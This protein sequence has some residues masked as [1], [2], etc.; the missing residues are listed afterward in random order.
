VLVFKKT[1]HIV[2]RCWKRFDHNY[3][4]KEKM[5][6]NAE[7]PRYSVNT[8]WYSDTGSTDHVTSELDKLAM[9]EKYT[10]PEQ[11]HAASGGGMHIA[12]VGHSM[13]Y[14]PTRHLMLKNFMHVPNSHKNLVSIHWFTRDNHMFIEY[15]PYF[16][17]V[18][19]PFTRKILLR[20]K[21]S[22]G[23]YPFPSLE[24]SSTWCVLT[25]VKPSI[26]H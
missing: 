2:L 3:T 8:S 17:L 25:T 22:G 21:C 11:I 5:V 13:L 19:D 4:D 26:N 20:G 24:Q 18:K 15:Q 6:N 10:V 16:F 14:T 1:G 7:G 12:H 23:L 9:R